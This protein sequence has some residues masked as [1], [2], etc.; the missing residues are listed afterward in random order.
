[1][2]APICTCRCDATVCRNGGARGNAV[3]V[4]IESGRG[5]GPRANPSGRAGPTASSST[6]RC[7]PMA[8]S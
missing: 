1:R 6:C 4:T 5:G 2:Y 3:D 7:R 8:T